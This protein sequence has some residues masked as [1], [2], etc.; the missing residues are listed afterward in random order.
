MGR[1]NILSGR[2][3]MNASAVNTFFYFGQYRF[4]PNSQ[5]LFLCQPTLQ[6]THQQSAHLVF[7]LLEI[8][9]DNA[10]IPFTI[11]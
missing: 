5:S 1:F 3:V 7:L 11:L 9:V 6:S 2:N 4:A 8:H 10:I